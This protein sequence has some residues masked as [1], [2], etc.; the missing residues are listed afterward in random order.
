MT[1]DMVADVAGYLNGLSLSGLTVP[2]GEDFV[3]DEPDVF[4]SLHQYSGLGPV[5][6]HSHGNLPA[7]E[8]P[9][10]QIRARASTAAAT[11][12][13]AYAAYFA[14]QDVVNTTLGGTRYLLIEAL[15]SPFPLEVDQNRRHVWVGNFNVLR[16]APHG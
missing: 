5:Y 3:R 14:L 11:K 13:L 9:G 8:R 4:L 12:A 10:L 15:A 7:Q 6:T 1:V 16:E 2:V